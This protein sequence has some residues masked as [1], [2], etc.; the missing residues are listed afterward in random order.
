[1]GREG[2]SAERTTADLNDDSYHLLDTDRASDT[3]L[4][5]PC[6]LPIFKETSWLKCSTLTPME[7]YA[8]HSLRS[9]HKVKTALKLP[10]RPRDGHDMLAAS[11]KYPGLF[12]VS[13][14][15]SP[16]R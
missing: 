5:V 10:P 13:A 12:P 7:V 4:S 15:S 11:Q 2:S 14:P 9:H 6:A 3:I 8:V 1:M 16:P